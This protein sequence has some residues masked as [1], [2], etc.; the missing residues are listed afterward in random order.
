[1]ASGG[2]AKGSIATRLTHEL[3]E[4]IVIAAYLYV[5]LTASLLAIAAA[6]GDEVHHSTFAASVVGTWA[7]KAENCAASDKSNVVIAADK[8]TDAN[9]TCTVDTVVERAGTPGP[10]YA[11]HGRCADPSQPG[12]FRI[13]NLIVRPLANDKVLIGTT[14]DDEKTY[15][16]CPPR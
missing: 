15:R 5:C 2:T 4:F 1:M 6:R 14:F 7:L 11:A 12:K 9:G 8:F 10:Y 13:A 16:R 3:R